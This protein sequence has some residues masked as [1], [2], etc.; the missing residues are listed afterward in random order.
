MNHPFLRF[1]L[2]G[3]LASSL[4]AAEPT[5]E[6]RLQALEQQVQ[7]LARENSELKKELGW[8]D[9]QAPVLVQPAGREAKLAVGGF[10]QAQGEFGHAADPRWTGVKDR[11]YF[12]RARIYVQGVIAEDFDFKAELDLQ[13]NSLGAATGLLA[14]ANEIY[15]GWH[16]YP[17]ATVRLGQLKAAFGAEQLSADTKGFTIERSLAND[18]LTDSRQLGL[19]VGGDVADKK[20]GYLLTVHNGTGPNVSANDNSKFQKAARVTFTPIATT[21]D[22]L[23]FGVSGL[24]TDDVGVSKSGFGFAGNLFTGERSAWGVDG[25]WHHGPLDLN[26]EWL[27]N[28]FKPAGGVEFEADGWSATAA[29][30]LVPARLQGVVRH[31]EFDPNTGA[32][33]DAMHSWTLG[34][35][36]LVK[37]EDLRFMVDYVYGEVPGA[38]TDGGRVLTRMQVLF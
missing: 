35:N 13:G 24:W 19:S 5:V 37:G 36:Y 30:Y 16:K 21:E 14:R 22:R 26:A 33:G 17:E 20:V 38:T 31:E 29:W 9:T 4:H 1:L 7:V 27:H 34:L 15:V 32:A 2:T 11:F 18:R 23:V 10:L 6:A 25:A 28:T 3:L 8:K 12:R